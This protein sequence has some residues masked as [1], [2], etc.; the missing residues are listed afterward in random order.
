[1]ADQRLKESLL[2]IP[3]KAPQI[4]DVALADAEWLKNTD[5]QAQLRAAGYNVPPASLARALADRNPPPPTI[6]SPPP[7]EPEEEPPSDLLAAN[8]R[9]KNAQADLAELKFKEAAAELIPAKDVE[10]QLV[11]YLT[12]CKTQLLAIPS[13]ARQALPHLASTD[14][15]VIERLVREALEQLAGPEV[16]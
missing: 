15:D 3:G 16:E 2:I 13:R 14:C 11:G 8:L 4:R 12:S 9:H 1:V 5:S 6:D 7:P 10:R